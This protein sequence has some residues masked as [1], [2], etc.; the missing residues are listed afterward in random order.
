MTSPRRS[1]CEALFPL[2]QATPPANGPILLEG[3]ALRLARSE[4][5]FLLEKTHGHC[6]ERMPM[7]PSH[8]RFHMARRNVRH[9]G[10]GQDVLDDLRARS[11]DARAALRATFGGGLFGPR[12][13]GRH[14]PIVP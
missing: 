13:F 10:L 8:P 12:P 4:Q 3:R 9:I 1:C 2:L 5:G 6:V 7:I 14:P 11:S